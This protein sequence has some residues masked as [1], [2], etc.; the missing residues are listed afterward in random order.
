MADYPHGWLPLLY[1][2]VLLWLVRWWCS[3]QGS[4]L[5]GHSAP[6]ACI[7]PSDSTVWATQLEEFTKIWKF[8]FQRWW[9]YHSLDV[10]F[11]SRENGTLTCFHCSS[12]LFLCSKVK[13]GST[14]VWTVSS[15]TPPLS[16][17]W[18]FLD[19]GNS[20][21]PWTKAADSLW[22]ILLSTSSSSSL[23]HRDSGITSSSR[24]K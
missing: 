10:Y 15:K 20:I 4:Q 24:H 3:T 17:H 11:R 19:W 2:W 18:S 7:V 14:S 5:R 16:S 21:F 9:Y 8:T 22:I 6:A 1:Q 12:I 23:Y 13:L